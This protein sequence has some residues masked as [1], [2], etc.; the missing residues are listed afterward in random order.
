MSKS[1]DISDILKAVG[2][3][4]AGI[5]SVAV[6]YGAQSNNISNIEK[7]VQQN[8]ANINDVEK[9]QDDWEQNGELPGDIRQDLR[10]E[11]IKEE[12]E[13]LESRVDK[14]DEAVRVLELNQ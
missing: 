7:D 8:T 2:I 6:A 10:I 1:V 3:S 14:L 11:D 9:W 5:L 12:I 13:R 4:A